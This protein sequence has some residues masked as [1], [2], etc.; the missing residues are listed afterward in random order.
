MYEKYNASVFAF[1][2]CPPMQLF[3]EHC[4][5]S[6]SRFPIRIPVTDSLNE[7]CWQRTVKVSPSLET[8]PVNPKTEKNKVI[9][10]SFQNSSE[11]FEMQLFGV[12]TNN[13][14]IGED[15]KR[16]QSRHYVTCTVHCTNYNRRNV[17]QK[18]GLSKSQSGFDMLSDM[19]MLCLYW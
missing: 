9:K 15:H 5:N 1:L 3:V 10:I 18:N 8:L 14:G 19:Y 12:E 17:I 6:F 16:N 7:E 2:L 13:F 4:T 11:F